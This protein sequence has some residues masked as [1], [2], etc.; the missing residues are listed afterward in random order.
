MFKTICAGF[1]VTPDVCFED[2]DPQQGARKE[3]GG[4]I[5]TGTIVGLVVALVLINVLLIYCY[6]RYTRR[7]IKDE[8]QLQISS[9]MSQYFALSDNKTKV[10]SA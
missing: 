7:E 3:A 9:M 2:Y 5:S 1:N 10:P 6:R 8:M 4:S